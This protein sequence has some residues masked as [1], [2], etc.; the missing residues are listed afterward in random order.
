[1]TRAEFTRLEDIINTNLG[2]ASFLANPDIQDTFWNFCVAYGF[3]VCKKAIID[4]IE[5]E[6]FNPEGRRV[7]LSLYIVE[8]KIE[9][10][11]RLLKEQEKQANPSERICPNC[12]N[13]GF[14]LKPAKE[15]AEF[16]NACGCPIGREKYP[17][18]F[19]T[20]A[21]LMESGDEGTR[22]SWNSYEHY[23]APKEYIRKAKYGE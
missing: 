14:F 10:E 2:K 12:G 21:E 20:P 19:M 18:F 22:R 1:M 11:A 23:K 13:T 6:E 7:P 17:W 8:R 4:L 5:N 3:E 15:A 9:R 16:F